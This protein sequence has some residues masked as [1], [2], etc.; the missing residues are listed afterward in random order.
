[1]L[2]KVVVLILLRTLC[3]SVT[4][5]CHSTRVFTNTVYSS[6]KLEQLQQLRLRESTE[7]SAR[8][9]SSPIY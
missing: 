8:A 5:E 9:S 2:I 6:H 4:N 1:M 3:K 7:L